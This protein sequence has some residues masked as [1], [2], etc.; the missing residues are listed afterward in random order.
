V[1]F[2]SNDLPKPSDITV[3]NG[4]LSNITISDLFPRENTKKPSAIQSSF[5][6]KDQPSSKYLLNLSS[7][8]LFLES[9]ILSDIFSANKFPANTS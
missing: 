4:F 9:G 7:T 6:S 5:E 2:P 1:F 3:C 8:Q